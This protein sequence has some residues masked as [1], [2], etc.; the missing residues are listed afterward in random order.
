LSGKLN[1]DGT[2]V[3]PS[4]QN[5]AKARIDNGRLKQNRVFSVGLVYKIMKLNDSISFVQHCKRIDDALYSTPT[6]VVGGVE[7]RDL[8]DRI[9]FG[10]NTIAHG[11]WGDISAEAVFYGL[12]TALVFYSQS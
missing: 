5:A 1:A 11:H 3:S 4:A 2:W 6:T 12:L 9:E 8:G 10:R 7:V